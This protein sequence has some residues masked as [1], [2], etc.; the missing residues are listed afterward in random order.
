MSFSKIV[1]EASIVVTPNV[2]KDCMTFGKETR[3]NEKII[4]FKDTSIKMQI[5]FL[6]YLLPM[7]DVPKIE[8]PQ[9]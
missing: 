3:Y 9:T 8:V 5:K 2:L 6:H 4:K 1:Y 7:R